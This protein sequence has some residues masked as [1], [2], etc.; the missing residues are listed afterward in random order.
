[1][2]TQHA[3][4]SAS[5][6]HRWLNCTPSARLEENYPDT[7]SVFAKEGTLA[8]SIGE[9]ILAQHIGT[10]T[11]KRF[12]KKMEDFEKN[13]LYYEGMVNEVEEYTNYCIERFV[14]AK[15]TDPLAELLIEQ[16]L[17][18]SEYV[19]SGFGTGDCLI[20][21]NGTL[22]VIDLK[23]GK[24]VEVEVEENPQ[25]M[26]Y[27]LAALL[28]H[29]LVYDIKTVR[30]TIA[31]VRLGSIRSWEIESEKLLHWAATVVR[32]KADLAYKGEGELHAG[33][34]CRFCKFRA[35]CKTRTEE[36][37]DEYKRLA[38]EAMT[39][40]DF[41]E[42]LAVKDEI[43]S[44]I[45]DI[46][47]EA[48]SRML[49]GSYI[50]GFK[51]VAGRSNRKITDP[52]EMKRRLLAQGYQEEQFLTKPTLEGISALEKLVGKKQFQS[53]GEGIVIKPDGKPTIAPESDKRPAIAGAETVFDFDE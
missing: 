7:S 32:P 42:V 35:E 52:E 28:E 20:L 37:L 27:G 39:P 11:T 6:A 25:L 3:L 16:R 5:G 24:G 43:K 10:L 15:K 12:L 21:A 34:W 30:L 38:K 8:H 40:E 18:F 44:W 1:M 19:P 48:L 17:D 22:E 31:Q 23:F 14:E 47:E 51:A 49:S 2:P 33:D 13:E 46:E 29:S 4:L 45:S 26:L 36:H 50:P 41:A 53:L 9:A